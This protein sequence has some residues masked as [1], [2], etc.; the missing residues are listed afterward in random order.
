MSGR[1]TCRDRQAAGDLKGEG[2]MDLMGDLPQL[3][4]ELWS[5]K[6][7]LAD[8]TQGLIQVLEVL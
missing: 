5:W 4:T 7:L 2:A 3:I 1:E 6:R 8:V